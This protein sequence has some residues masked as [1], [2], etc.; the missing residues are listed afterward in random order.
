M[1]EYVDSSPSTAT[2]SDQTDVLAF[3]LNFVKFNSTETFPWLHQSGFSEVITT[4]GNEL[5]LFRRESRDVFVFI[6]YLYL[7]YI[8]F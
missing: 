2:H 5:Y 1:S 8:L 6:N 4:A 7:T 3:L